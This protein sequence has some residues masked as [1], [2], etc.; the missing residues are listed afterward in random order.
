V[1]KVSHLSGSRGYSSAALT[2]DELHD[3]FYVKM[4]Y[5]TGR[6]DVETVGAE[7]V[8]RKILS[9]GDPDD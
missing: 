2:P 4:L 6:L 3:V 5:L 8:L 9:A 7:T 1:A